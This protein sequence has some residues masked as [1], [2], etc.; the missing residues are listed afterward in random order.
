MDHNRV[1]DHLHRAVEDGAHD[2]HPAHQL[3]GVDVPDGGLTSFGRREVEAGETLF[4]DVRSV[5]VPGPEGDRSCRIPDLG[6]VDKNLV[7]TLARH[8]VQEGGAAQVDDVYEPLSIFGSCFPYLR[9]QRVAPFGSAVATP[10]AVV[11]VNT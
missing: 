5:R 8:T 11:G 9:R 3:P 4:E 6:A 1:H 7:T 2:E 10:N